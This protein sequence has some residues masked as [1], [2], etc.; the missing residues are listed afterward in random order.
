MSKSKLHIL[1]QVKNG[2]HGQGVNFS[3]TF[4]T[5]NIIHCLNSDYDYSDCVAIDAHE[6]DWGKAVDMALKGPMCE[7]SLPPNTVDKFLDKHKR[8][9]TDMLP[10]LG[11]DFKTIGLMTLVSEGTIC[12]LDY[13]SRD[14]Y[15]NLWRGAGAKIG[16][17]VN[18]QV[19]WEQ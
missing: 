17:V 1:K 11:G 9:L 3:V 2:W 15:V 10:G 13:V 4:Y 18:G 8:T 7:P 6:I 19:E 5:T 12:S 14:I 16:K